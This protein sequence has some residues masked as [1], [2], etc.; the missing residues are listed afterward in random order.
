MIKRFLP[1]QRGFSVL[2]VIA[3]LTIAT[4][5]AMTG[6]A[7]LQTHGETAQSRACEAHRA[8]L[9][10]DVT[11][12]EQ[13]NGRLPTSAMRELADA[14]Y[15]GEVLPTCPTSGNAYRLDRGNVV[16]PTHGQ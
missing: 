2:E 5:F 14:D 9:Q 11:L 1:P 3:A 13:E 15:T 6:L 8:A 7:F 4:M 12:Y 16:C 10:S